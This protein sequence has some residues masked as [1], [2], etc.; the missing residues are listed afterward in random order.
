MMIA[1]RRP[2][3]SPESRKPSACNENVILGALTEISRRPGSWPNGARHC[4]HR[5]SPRHS[6]ATLRP[7]L[8]PAVVVSGYGF[9]SRSNLVALVPISS[10]DNGY[11]L[12]VRI[13]AEVVSGYAF[14]EALRT[15]DVKQRGFRLLGLADDKAMK[16]IMTNIRGIFDLR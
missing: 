10:T 16:A 6:H 15:L 1:P 12:H 9:N 4:V 2:D 13:D 7:K 5:H 14:V 8:R 3:A 11:P